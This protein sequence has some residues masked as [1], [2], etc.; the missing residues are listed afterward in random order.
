[1]STH[2]REYWL[3]VQAREAIESAMGMSVEQSEI[4]AAVDEPGSTL[5]PVVGRATVGLA[6]SKAQWDA[7]Y[8]LALAEQLHRRWVGMEEI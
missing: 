1:M 7:A 3:N 4:D 6:L 2:A 8:H 5:W